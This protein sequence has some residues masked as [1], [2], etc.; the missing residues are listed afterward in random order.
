[1]T[2]LLESQVVAQISY[3]REEA[4]ESN[5][6]SNRP[7]A[8]SLAT[9]V[10][11]LYIYAD[12]LGSASTTVNMNNGVIANS[13]FYPFGE[14]QKQVNAK[15]DFAEMARTALGR[16]YKKRSV[17]QKAWFE[18]ALKEIITRTVYPEAPKF[19]KSVKI[20]Y[21]KVFVPD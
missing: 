8:A 13:R 16:E 21:K 4:S 2:Y 6:N 9:G 3:S 17:E 1:M 19:L 7:T 20:K 12:H 14:L 11:R 5:A 10:N 18:S 15:I